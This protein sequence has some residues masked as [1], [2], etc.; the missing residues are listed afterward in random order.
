MKRIIQH[1]SK[2]FQKC[3]K[4]STFS[5]FYLKSREFQKFTW[6]LEIFKNSL[7][8]SRF[9]R[10]HLESQDFQEFIWNLKIFKNS[11]G[12]STF[13][14]IHLDICKKSLGIPGF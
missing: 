3:L 4:I 2:E 9:S 14:R 7:G 11:L 13:S 10:I 5:R 8:I 6:N 1:Q 12:I